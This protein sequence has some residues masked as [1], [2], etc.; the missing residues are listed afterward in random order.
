MTRY[1]QFRRRIAPVAFGLA[2]AFIAYDTCTKQERTSA[3]VVLDFGAA[4]PDVRSVEASVWMDGEPVTE[5]RRT[6][7]DGMQIGRAQFKATLPGDRGELRADVELRSGDRRNITR[8]LHVTEG[9][10]ITVQLER[11][12]R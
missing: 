5:F 10:T 9:G 7:L 2:I 3:T 8:T 1:D 4:A 11:D 12:L 6:A